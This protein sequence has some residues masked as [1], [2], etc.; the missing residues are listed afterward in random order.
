MNSIPIIPPSV[1]SSSDYPPLAVA[2]SDAGRNLPARAAPPPTTSSPA[3]DIPRSWAD[4]LAARARGNIPARVAPPPS[5][6]IPASNIP[7]TIVPSPYT[8][9]WL[10]FVEA[11]AREN[12]PARVAPPP[13]TSSPDSDIPATVAPP[14]TTSSPASDIPRSWA[15]LVAAQAR[16][17]IPARVAPPPS[18]R[19]PASNIPV[20]IVPSPNTMSWLEFVEARARGNIPARVAPPPTTNSPDSDIPAT[21]APPPTTSSPASNVPVTDELSPDTSPWQF[22]GTRARRNIPARVAPP[23][24]T[25]SPASNIPVAVAP[26]RTPPTSAS[27]LV[28]QA[29]PP[30]NLGKSARKKAAKRARAA[31]QEQE[32]QRILASQDTELPLLTAQNNV[33]P[34]GNRAGALP[35]PAPAPAPL[36]SPRGPGTVYRPRFT[37]NAQSQSPLPQNSSDPEE[38][39][40]DY[41]YLQLQRLLQPQSVV[42]NSVAEAEPERSGL[43]YNASTSTQTRGRRMSFGEYMDM[44]NRGPEPESSS[45][46]RMRP[47]PVNSGTGWGEDEEE[48]NPWDVAATSGGGDWETGDGGD[49]ETVPADLLRPEPATTILRNATPQDPPPL[50]EE[51]RQLAEDTSVILELIGKTYLGGNTGMDSDYKQIID[52]AFEN[53]SKIRTQYRVALALKAGS[54]NLTQGPAPIVEDI[55]KIDSA[56][57][58]C[59]DEVT[60][61]VLLPCNHLVLCM[62]CSDRM[63]IKG[64]ST[65]GA[66]TV[67]CP[68]CRKLVLD[69]I[70]IF[71]G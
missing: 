6:S 69:R 10:E 59:C 65:P 56:C 60:D 15:N 31:M 43:G 17:N 37:G 26:S 38:I 53:I 47:S 23:P 25:R 45:S 71:R 32:L 28:G 13:T 44:M 67:T 46:G 22:V 2:A 3:S 9:S 14:P 41:S 20:T 8:M 62:T 39:S 12:I 61:T 50:S 5:T 51:M 35:A 66:R 54:V 33:P 58:I 21:V 19:S 55:L 63:G 7:V 64:K 40:N 68:I 52:D 34:P 36:Y 48:E 49:W 24:S 42:N 57:I 16:G 70:K 29:A 27:P 30:P 4:L 11:R 18:T 1:S